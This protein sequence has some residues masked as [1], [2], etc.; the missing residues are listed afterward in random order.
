MYIPCSHL[1]M[2]WHGTIIQ[3]QSSMSC[4][5]HISCIFVILSQILT[6]KFIKHAGIL[7]FSLG[8]VHERNCHPDEVC[9]LKN[10][11]S[12]VNCEVMLIDLSHLGH[13]SPFSCS[14]SFNENVYVQMCDSDVWGISRTM[15]YLTQ[16]I[17]PKFTL[18]CVI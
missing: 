1:Y 3:I 9:L 18:H 6:L 2:N 14:L 7:S 16:M 8:T 4:N 15:I 11:P 13:I 5:D 12:C 10:R 17:A